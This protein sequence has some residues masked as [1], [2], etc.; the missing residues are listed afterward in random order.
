MSVPSS[1]DRIYGRIS[2][3][4][5]STCVNIVKY[6]TFYSCCYQYFNYFCLN[7]VLNTIVTRSFGTLLLNQERQFV[8]N[9]Y[10]FYP[11]WVTVE[12]PDV[13]VP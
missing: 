1:Y 12:D 6:Q 7:G 2:Y 11:L 10:Y 9:V 5:E 13:L 4:I 3:E 8:L